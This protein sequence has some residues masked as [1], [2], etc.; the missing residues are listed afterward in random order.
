[1]P[2][3]GKDILPPMLGAKKIQAHFFDGYWEDIGTIRA[4]Y[5]ANLALAEAVPKFNF[6]DERFM[7]FT[8]QRHLPGAKINQANIRSSVLCDGAIVSGS[9]VEQS[10]I[11]LRSVIA[12]GAFVHKTVMM[13][14]DYYDSPGS[15]FEDVPDKA[16]SLGIGHRTIVKNAIIDKNARIAED[17]RIVN[18]ENVQH[19]DGE[20]YYIR[21][22]IV[23]IPRSAVIP[24]GTVI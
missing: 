11:G 6:Y 15:R 2:D 14:A 5:E 19:A 10:V 24:A 20:N 3:F 16:P 21:D 13:G 22:G 12:E 9:V 7:I 17:C 8:R 1:G 18:Q 4:F 23:C